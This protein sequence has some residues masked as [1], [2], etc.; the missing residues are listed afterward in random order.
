MQ[1]M[2]KGAAKYQESTQ[3]LFQHALSAMRK[4]ISTNMMVAQRGQ[5]LQQALAAFIVCGQPQLVSQLLAAENFI[6]HL[7]D[8]G[9]SASTVLAQSIIDASNIE[10]PELAAG[11]LDVETV[12]LVWDAMVNVGADMT[13]ALPNGNLAPED[14]PTF[15]PLSALRCAASPLCNILALDLHGS[16]ILNYHHDLPDLLVLRWLAVLS[17]LSRFGTL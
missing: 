5:L 7:E 13:A 10:G 3:L 11:Q 17:L 9:S 12:Q 2:S 14:K 16:A 15:A 4:E 1:V 6:M 8:Q